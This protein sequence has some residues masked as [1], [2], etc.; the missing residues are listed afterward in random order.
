[1]QTQ[2]FLR[3]LGFDPDMEVRQEASLKISAFC[4]HL[5]A[6][7]LLSQVLPVLRDLTTPP[8]AQQDQESFASNQLVREAVC[9]Q[10]SSIAPILGREATLNELMPLMKVFFNDEQVCCVP[11]SF[12]H[13]C[14][15]QC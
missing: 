10:V 2:H 7:T 3:L 5:D 13:V 14:T 9:A 1:V 4:S 8:A 6:N 11:S 12:V 15:L